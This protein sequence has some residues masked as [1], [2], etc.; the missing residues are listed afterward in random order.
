MSAAGF[1][2]ITADY[3]VM[4]V[5]LTR[6]PLNI[7]TIDMMHE[8]NA[9]L[10]AAAA[11]PALKVLVLAA[12][13]K[14]FC[15]GVAV[16]DHVGERV[17]P[18]LEVF[19]EIFRRLHALPCLTLAAVQGAAIGGGA[20][21]ATFCDVVVAADHATIGQPEIKLGVFPPVAALHYPRRIGVPR[22]LA[23]LLSGDTLGAAEAQRIG[24]V[25]HVVPAATLE[26]V[27]QARLARVRGHSAAVLRLTRRAVLDGEGRDFMEALPAVEDLYMYELMTT[28][29]AGEGL[30]AFMDK[31]RPV[32]KDR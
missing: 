14:A 17:K 27:V 2:R 8:I 28:E 25:D 31:R 7:L 23:L 10:A 11:R 32:W 26:E 19:H 12:E 18:M 16:E 3:D 20:E 1:V 24:L 29:D 22:T 4:R 9:A 15:A 5:T 6:P 30:R 21:L 13:G